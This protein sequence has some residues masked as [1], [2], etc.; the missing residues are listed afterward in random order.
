MGRRSIVTR[1]DA[2]IVRD[3][4]A[5]TPFTADEIRGGCPAGRTAGVLVEPA[6]GEPFIR[7]TRFVDANADGAVEEFTRLTPDGHPIDGP[8]TDRSTWAELQG[9]AS[10]PSG[11]TTI[12][13]EVLHGPLGRLDCLRYTVV[14]GSSVRTFW[15]ARALPGMPV[16][17]VTEEA[18]RVTM[19]VTMVA[20]TLPG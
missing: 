5:P 3:G 15:F 19:T 7:V 13:P 2:H 6:H 9:H 17:V 4:H 10:F 8:E 12:E 11:Q 1:H 14:D 16:K 18:G 20:N